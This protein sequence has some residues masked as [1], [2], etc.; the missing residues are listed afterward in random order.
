M[1]LIIYEVWNLQLCPRARRASMR[2]SHAWMATF[3]RISL[4]DLRITDLPIPITFRSTYSKTKK[5]IACQHFDSQSYL[6]NH[7][8]SMTV[9]IN[10]SHINRYFRPLRLVRTGLW[11]ALNRTASA[12]H[13]HGLF[14]EFCHDLPVLRHVHLRYYN[15]LPL[16]YCNHRDTYRFYSFPATVTDLEITHTFDDFNKFPDQVYDS[17]S[18]LYI[19]RYKRDLFFC[20]FPWKLPHIRRLIVRGG[21]VPLVLTVALWAKGLEEI[22]TDIDSKQVIQDLQSLNLPTIRVTRCSPPSR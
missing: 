7:C 3:M 8:R 13:Y 20:E 16:D 22:T 19:R 6:E 4:E 2:V 17:R 10:I 11:D 15:R 9:Y 5:S 1:E 18:D 12:L 14:L 21:H